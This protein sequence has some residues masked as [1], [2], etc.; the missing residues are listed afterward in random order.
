[1]SQRV[2]R[3][4]TTILLRCLPTAL[5]GLVVAVTA[6]AQSLRPPTL[7][8][9]VSVVGG[10]VDSRIPVFAGSSDCGEFRDGGSVET[11]A[12]VSFSLDGI[13]GSLGFGASLWLARATS[14][15]TALPPV[16]TRI[17]D[18]RTGEIVELEREYRRERTELRG[19]IDLLSRF[20][21]GDYGLALGP[22]LA[23]DVSSTSEQTDNVTGPGPIRFGDGQAVRVMDAAHAS[24]PSALTVGLTLEASRRFPLGAATL[25]PFVSG[26]IDLTSRT[27]EGGVRAL[28]VGAG[29]RVA[30]D[31]GAMMRADPIAVSTIETARP[32]RTPPLQAAL[33]IYGVDP[34]GVR[35]TT[36][37]ITMTELEEVS[38]VPMVPAVFFDAHTDSISARYA[39][40]DNDASPHPTVALQRRVLDTIGARLAARPG[41]R[42]LLIPGTS[43]DESPE[44]AA[45]R[46]RAV[47][48][49]LLER[50]HV[51]AA[52]AVV[53]DGRGNLGRSSE[54]VEDGREDNRRVEF[55]SPSP[56]LLAPIVTRRSVRHFDPPAIELVPTIEAPA[57]IAEWRIVMLR[58]DREVARFSSRDE[59]HEYPVWEILGEEGDSIS[60]PLVARLEVIDSAGASV[61][62]E[63]RTT[64]RIVRRYREVDRR[65]EEKEDRTISRHHLVAFEF[66]RAE[67]GSLNLV[68]LEAIA[69]TIG[70]RARVR[71]VGGAD[72]I[73][74]RGHN[75][76]LARR[77]AEAVGDALDAMLARR[78]VPSV[79]VETSPD[80][81]ESGR[82]TNDLP[83]GRFLSRGVEVIVDQVR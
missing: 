66:D 43:S 25:S 18:E 59:R 47:Q 78:G 56:E 55:T 2:I 6:H 48:R 36:P 53:R 10:P 34:R 5:A 38:Y 77:R 81:D 61:M 67:P 52:R 45:R 42:I 29:A 12:G 16:P 33:S 82:F 70:P 11:T 7:G 44:L 64:V 72:R 30:F 35:Q 8:G 21:F 24:A 15:L 54:H 31:L 57:G 9:Y 20:S 69:A 17:R 76:E 37:E 73:G 13:A 23:F 3:V 51:D 39:R 4:V 83:E 68:Q 49:E 80:V 32:L 14:T 19:G 74:D 40:G 50:W 63:A 46:A 79:T 41:A 71:V 62:T 26:R 58:G 75:V 27:E 65:S 22:T 60:A 1:M 28:V